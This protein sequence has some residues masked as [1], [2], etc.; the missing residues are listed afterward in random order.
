MKDDFSGAVWVYLLKTKG[1]TF[2][3]FRQF[4]VWIEKQTEKKIKQLRAD[5]GG[6][7]ISDE[8]QNFLKKEGIQW[9]PRAPYTPEQNG[10]AEQQNYTLMVSVRSVLKAK[11]LPKSLWGEV[12]RTSTYLKNRSPGVD[13]ITPYERINNTKPFLGH[14]RII[15][16]RAWVHI[17]KE[18]QKKLDDRSW[19][20]VLVGYEGNNQ[21]RVYDPLT[22]K[23][24]I[25]RDVT[26]DE[27]N[28]FDLKEK[29]AWDLADIP[30][31]ENDDA[32]F[33]DPD[34]VSL[35]EKRQNLPP[36]STSTPQTQVRNPDSVPP[37]SLGPPNP[38]G[39]DNSRGP[40]D[41]NDEQGNIPN[42]PNDE[43][44]EEIICTPRRSDRL[45]SL[46]QKALDNVAPPQVNMFKSNQVPRSHE[47]MVRVLATLARGEDNEGSDEPQ[48]LKEAMALPY[49][50]QWKKAMEAKYIS[51]MEN[52]TWTL[53]T[54]PADRKVI[55]GRWTF[56]LKK[57]KHGKI[58]KFKARWV[59]HGYKQKE[60]LDYIDTFATV[61]KPVSY[62]ALMGI[63]VK[64]G[65]AIYHMD[66]VTAFLYGFLDELIY[67]TQPIMFETGGSHMV[68]LLRKALYGLKQSP[69]VWYQ[70]LQDFLHKMGFKRT[71]SDHGVFVSGDMFIAIYVD[72]LFIF[73]KDT[74]KVQQ[75]QYELKSRFRMTDLGEVSHY[76]GIE[77]D[78][79]SDKSVI[80]LQQTTY[81][82]KVL[83]R[84]NMLNSTPIS[85]PMD[86]G[87]GNTIMPSE[88]QADKE[89]ITWYQSVV[90]SLMWPA[91]H[92]RPDIAYAVGVLSR[93]CSNPGPLHCKYLQR[94]MRYLASTLDV[95]LVFRGNTGNDLV[96]YSDADYAGTKNGRKST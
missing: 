45:K 71:E 29:K 41:Q 14:L 61:V 50:E 55:T 59:V 70:T 48:T 7:Y 64:R 23:T 28:I 32:E 11:K 80:T 85:T 8:F 9:D 25:C 95:G 36:L 93:Y 88:D 12:L 89:T 62:K 19:Q 4:K 46:T 3:Y 92:T 57:D 47:H 76:L 51:L 21:Y 40:E 66:V 67:V 94:I 52:E 77:V 79:N 27:N 78:V 49:W 5:G 86:P 73:G 33:D 69:R 96:G 83:S 1:Q 91:M 56:K 54:A 6:E 17:P 82:K 58:L 34:D 74:P 24:H 38:M 84:F 31:G 2:E 16:A 20:G 87:A 30:W 53:E 43:A 26:I 63:S 22:G 39:A 42:N 10:K 65:L 72:D 81:L 37:L 90:G 68:C 13:E 35:R 75:L 15:G 18:R 44:D 60:G